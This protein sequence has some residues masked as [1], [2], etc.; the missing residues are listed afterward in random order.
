MRQFLTLN[1]LPDF[2]H[3]K[4]A[5]G[6]SLAMK[7]A[8]QDLLGRPGEKAAR[9]VTMTVTMTPILQQ[10]GDVV[11]AEVSFAFQNKF[12]PMRTN[13]MPCA[14]DAQGRLVFN[15]LAADNPHQATIDEAVGD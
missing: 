4:A 6:F 9:S 14:V 5:A 12:P 2:A 1:S 11:D 13:P 15:D 3:G 8:V 7:R 10:D